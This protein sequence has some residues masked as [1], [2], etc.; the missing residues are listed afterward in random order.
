MLQTSLREAAVVL[1][2]LGL[3][4]AWLLSSRISKRVLRT[5]M[6]WCWLLIVV[7][8]TTIFLT[9]W[10]LGGSALSGTVAHGIYRVMEHGHPSEVTDFSYYFLAGLE[11]LMFLLVPAGFLMAIS[12]DK[13]TRAK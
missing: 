6:A 8:G 11:L 13:E 5:V 3:A 12:S 1:A 9:S 4:A 7:I 10:R 2:A